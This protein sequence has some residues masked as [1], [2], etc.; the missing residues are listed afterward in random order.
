MRARGNGTQ[1]DVLS[2]SSKKENQFLSYSQRDR[3]EKGSPLEQRK[4]E[5]H[6]QNQQKEQEKMREPPQRYE[7]LSRQESKL[8][9]VPPV[10]VD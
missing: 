7:K 3:G 1:T 2:G 5:E 10:E 9:T 6:D 4:G 8:L